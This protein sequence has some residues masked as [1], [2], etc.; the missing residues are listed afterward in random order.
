MSSLWHTPPTTPAR[1][2]SGVGSAQRALRT[3]TFTGAA[4]AV[5]GVVVHLWDPNQPGSYG[6]CPLRATTGLLCPMCGG[7]RAVHALTHGEWASAWLLNPV[8]VALLPLALGAWILWVW[9]AA[10]GHPS[11]YL[12]RMKVFVPVVGLF[13]LFGVARNVPLFEPYLAAMT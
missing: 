12:E 5:T 3:A 7:L 2:L 13:V 10:Q 1:M 4:V 11:T 8:L 9:R 6:F